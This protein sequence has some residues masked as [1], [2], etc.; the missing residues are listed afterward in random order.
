ML[1]SAAPSAPPPDVEALDR[2][3]AGASDEERAVLLNDLAFSCVASQPE[4]AI[5]YAEQLLELARRLERP[6]VEA[7]ALDDIGLAHRY[8]GEY[9]QALRF[10]LEALAVRERTGDRA[11]LA[12]SYNNLGILYWRLGDFPRAVDF[13]SRA[14]A[15]KREIGAAASVPASLNN[16]ALVY[17]SMGELERAGACYEELLALVEAAGGDDDNLGKYLNNLGELTRDLGQLERSLGYAERA[18]AADR[19]AGNTSGLAVALNTLGL[20]QQRRGDLAAARRAFAEALECAEQSGNRNTERELHRSLADLLE[21]AGEPGPALEHMRRHARLSEEIFSRESSQR[22]AELQER[23]DH[24]RRQREIL[25][26][27]SEQALGE[28]ELAR[29]RSV[30][31]LLVLLSAVL[32]LVTG[33]GMAAVRAFRRSNRVIEREKARAEIALAELQVAHR[34]VEELSRTD[35]LTGLLNRRG[36]AE[37]VEREVERG[38]ATGR[39]LAVVLGDIDDFKAVNDD[40]G[41]DCGDQVLREVAAAL[42][43]QLRGQDLVGRWGGEEFLVV[44]PETDLAG[45]R[46]VAESVRRRLRECPVTSDG[47]RVEVRMTLGVSVLEPGQGFEEAVRAADDALLRGKAAGKN[48]VVVHDPG[49]GGGGD[50]GG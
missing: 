37:R 40:H 5:A 25:A 50:P 48:R 18:V 7:N 39:P 38:A 10:A 16:L 8:R 28:V 3:L 22:V 11:Q 2:R 26:L 32:L 24:E 41:H 47:V 44:L 13:H 6:L 14:L 4:R 17:Q 36:M 19:R 31:N 27:R 1:V 20:V 45:G 46:S 43:L 23:Y 35:P 21:A 12:G 49:G 34:Q 29:Q 42:R 15:V 9:E 30:R 33:A